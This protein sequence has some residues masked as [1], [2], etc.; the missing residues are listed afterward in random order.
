MLKDE[1]AQFRG[2]THNGTTEKF[3]RSWMISA[4]RIRIPSVHWFAG[5][6]KTHFDNISAFDDHDLTNAVAEGLTRVL[7]IAENRASGWRY[8]DTFTDIIF[9]IA[10]DF[11]ISAYGPRTFRIL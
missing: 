10:A 4:L 9:L 8:L 2:V 5:T 7:K 3:L 6:L 1:F 11:D